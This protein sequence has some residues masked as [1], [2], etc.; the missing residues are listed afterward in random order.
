MPGDGRLLALCSGFAVA[1]AVYFFAFIWLPGGRAQI[2][3][4]LADLAAALPHGW[5]RASNRG[6]SG[7]T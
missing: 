2:A 7:P 1:A 3:D 5:T 6:P 4:L